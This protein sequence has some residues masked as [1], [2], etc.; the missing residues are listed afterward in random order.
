MAGEPSTALPDSFSFGGMDSLTGGG[1]FQGSS[2]VSGDDEQSF[3]SGIGG[4]G[5]G[6]FM[7]TNNTTMQVIPTWLWLVLIVLA[8]GYFALKGR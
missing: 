1:G 5:F 8:I 2:G 7:T 3:S 4:I 6:D